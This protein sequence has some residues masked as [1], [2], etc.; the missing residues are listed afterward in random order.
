MKSDT[1]VFSEPRVIKTEQQYSSY[2][3]EVDRLLANGDDLSPEQNERLDLL[4]LLI[5]SY[6][7]SVYP[8]EPPD[9]IDAIK[10]RMDQQ[11]LKQADLVPY[12][13]TRGRVSE[14]L[15]RKRPLTI[16][17]IRSLSV[18]LGIS[19]ETLVGLGA[20]DP[21]AS[22]G[23]EVDWSKFPAK[24]MIAR[25]W[26]NK[27]AGKSIQSVESQVQK[28]IKSIGWDFQ[29]A[30]F[31]R[32]IYGDAYSAST[33]Y[34]LYAWLARVVQK[35][36]S[37]RDDL[38][39]YD[40][41][42]LTEDTLRELA[43]LSWFE[44]GPLLAIE[45][46]RK[47]GISIVIEPHLRR[48]LLDGAALKDSDGTP[49]IALTL[50]HDRLDNFWFTLLHEAVHIWKHVGQEET[51]LD[52]LDASTQDRREAEANRIA[53]DS[54]IPRIAWRRSEVSRNP[55]EENILEL[56]RELKISPA[57]IAGRIRREHGNHRIFSQLVGYGETRKLFFE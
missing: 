33:K 24:E 38:P 26:I 15:N 21:K 12:F 9:P 25:G 7:R 50:R 55:T 46:L 2:L 6:E 8:I 1:R 56:S 44:E 22:K 32:S 51:F 5:E 40:E 31:K 57:I 16:P 10:F 4:T 18:G 3:A 20:E 35:S 47:I 49:I 11:N 28:F 29:D 13:G 42:F 27:A 23:L 53:K 34:A 54:L 41:K 45:F 43:Q 14:V 17:M 36:R 48:T 52:D 39:K 37:Q 30:A 19:A